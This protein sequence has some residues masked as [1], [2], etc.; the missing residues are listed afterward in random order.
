MKVNEKCFRNSPWFDETVNKIECHN[1]VQNLCQFILFTSVHQ[2]L[3]LKTLNL[4]IPPENHT[5][6]HS[7]R[8]TVRK[9]NL[10]T[11]PRPLGS[12]RPTVIVHLWIASYFGCFQFP[13]SYMKMY[14]IWSKLICNNG[15]N[16]KVT[17][18][19]WW[20][21]RSQWK[22]SWKSKWTR[23]LVVICGCSSGR[24]RLDWMSRSHQGHG[25][26]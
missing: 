25:H 20:R 13:K 4:N 10:D 26:K 7:P 3:F 12:K 15:L 23:R 18:R 9:P 8:W 6:S 24:Q 16:V 11:L 2:L 5:R 19:S 21:S 1:D 22:S 14:S 17:S